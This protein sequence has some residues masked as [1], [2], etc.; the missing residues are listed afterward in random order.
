MSTNTQVSNELPL[1][2]A[3]PRIKKKN[4]YIDIW[5]RLLKNKLAVVSLGVLVLLVLTALLADVIAPYPANEQ[6]LTNILQA[7]NALHWLGTDAYG[8]DILSRIIYGSRISLQVGFVAVT[9]SVTLGG[10]IGAIAGFYGGSTDNILMR[11]MDILLA[12]PGILLAIAIVNVLGPGL[13]NVMIAVGIASLPTYARIVRASVLSIR[14]QEFVEASRAIGESNFSIIRRNVLPNCLA[15]I[16]VQATLGVAW[17]IL[18]AAGL[19]F[20][21][22]GLQPPTPEWGAMLSEGRQY[23][24]EAYWVTTFPGIAIALVVLALNIFGDGLRDAMDPRLKQ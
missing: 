13:V 9:F 11:F 4:P 10:I 12:I 23:I 16:I 20:I 1:P 3:K 15:P 22:L 21:G 2:A 24:Y 17:A 7:P 18:S 5:Y 19:S 6:N 8:R 14:D